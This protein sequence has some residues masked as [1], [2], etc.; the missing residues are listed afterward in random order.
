M[1]A[2]MDL[3]E[4]DG[5]VEMEAIDAGAAARRSS[6]TTGAPYR[7]YERARRRNPRRAQ[8]IILGAGAGDGRRLA[9]SMKNMSSPSPHQPSWF[10]STDMVTPDELAMAF[11]I[12][13]DVIALAVEIGLVVD[14]RIAVCFQS[15]VQP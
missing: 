1:V 11:G 2:L 7:S 8:E 15:L 6:P 12:H 5:L 10:C 3:V 9:P 4:G 13:K 14:Q